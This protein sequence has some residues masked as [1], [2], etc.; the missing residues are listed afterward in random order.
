M[1]IPASIVLAAVPAAVLIGTAAIRVAAATG[2]AFPA[3]SLMQPDVS[4]AV[5]S[6]AGVFV[7]V[8]D[9]IVNGVLSRFVGL[10]VLVYSMKRKGGLTFGSQKPAHGHRFKFSPEL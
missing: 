6:H 9:L 8:G 1:V 5:F 2:T 10:S 3:A 7:G 4:H